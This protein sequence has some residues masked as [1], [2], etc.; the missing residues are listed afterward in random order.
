MKLIKK[1]NWTYTVL[2]TLFLVLVITYI[3]RN[4]S[5]IFPISSTNNAIYVPI[6][7]YHQVK[8]KNLGK[9][10]ISA[11]EFES[12]L[13]YLSEN[14]YNVI[15][16]NQLIDHVYNGKE[17]PL[18]PI[19]LTFDD[20]YLNTYK[21]VFPLLKQYNM[22]IVLSVVGKCIDDFSRVCDD[23]VNYAHIT[24]DQLREMYDSGL[25]EIQNHTYDLHKIKNG[26]YGCYQVKD[27]SLEHYQNILTDDLTK[28]QDKVKDITNYN[29]TTF[30][31]PY[32]KYN[33]TTE[34]IIKNLGFKA[35]L[36]CT[37]GINV[38]SENPETLFGLKRMCRS[39]N[40]DIEELLKDGMKTI[41]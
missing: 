24:W 33:D 9:N 29:P 2:L 13:K 39:H 19:V 38:I 23:N 7:M 5:E 16:V 12:D 31:Y 14:N 10:A 21:F 37:Y 18:N 34:S 35:T 32:G 6:V 30:T 17:L 11:Y 40:Y 26:R 20:G 4:K 22:P 15:T 1:I 27:E 28:L 3:A 8:D 36:S 25:V 41:R